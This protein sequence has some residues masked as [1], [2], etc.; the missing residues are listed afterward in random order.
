MLNPWEPVNVNLLG[1]RVFEE[2]IK[3]RVLRCGILDYVG[4]P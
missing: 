4:G 2:V 1:K 3:L